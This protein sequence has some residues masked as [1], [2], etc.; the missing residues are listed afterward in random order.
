MHSLML[1]VVLLELGFMSIILLKLILFNK[2]ILNYAKICC[3]IH[4]E[5]EFAMVFLLVQNRIPVVC[6]IAKYKFHERMF[7]MIRFNKL[8]VRTYL[9]FCCFSVFYSFHVTF[10]CHIELVTLNFFCY[11]M[12]V[13]FELC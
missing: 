10:A 7:Q 9:T 6:Y 2:L 4:F 8:K 1:L 3:P 11:F 13:T 5:R 12:S